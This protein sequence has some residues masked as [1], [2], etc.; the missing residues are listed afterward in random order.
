MRFLVS[1]LYKLSSGILGPDQLPPSEMF[2][3]RYLT[4]MH[5]STNFKKIC[6]RRL[7]RFG[8]ESGSLWF[9]DG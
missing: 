4:E 9:N 5:R 8:I 2:G 1:K 6:G 7:V 3:P